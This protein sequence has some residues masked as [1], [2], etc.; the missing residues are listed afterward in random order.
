MEE[1]RYLIS[2]AARMTAV[3]P[4][5][6][7]Y[8]EEELELSIGRTE[9][10]HRY[11]TR[12]NIEVFRNIKELKEKGL[13]LKAI[14]VVLQELENRKREAAEKEIEGEGKEERAENGQDGRERQKD[15]EISEEK[16]SGEEK[17]PE[18]TGKKPEEKAEKEKGQEKTALA[19]MEDNAK[20]LHQFE[21]LVADIVDKVVRENNEELQTR[22]ESSF[23]R[24]MD[25][26]LHTQEAREEER[27]RKLDE[28]IR[29]HQKNG[30]MVAATKEK[31]FFQRWRR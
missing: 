25:Y 5:V 29:A 6:L 26:L 7:R 31:R 18:I 23:S 24:E 2:D 12:E 19:V 21:A 11:Y 30:K 8:W 27:F 10:G 3:E 13:Q 20:K 1:Q 14:K 28:A 4:H 15:R 9:L 22:I 17:N 16:G